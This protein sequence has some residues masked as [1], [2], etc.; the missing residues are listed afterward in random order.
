MDQK[1]SKTKTV[2]FYLISATIGAVFIFSGFVKAI[3]P[4]GTVYKIEDYLVAMHLEALTPLATVGAFALFTFEFSAGVMLLFNRNLKLG[5]W[6]TT[7]FMV[8]MTAMTIWIAAADPVSDCGCFGDAIVLSNK[9]TLIK[10]IIIDL[11]LAVLWFLHG[12]ITPPQSKFT[13]YT[14][15]LAFFLAIIGFGVHAINNLPLIDFRPYKI[16]TNILEA[17]ELP[18]GATP[19]EYETTFIYSKDGIE[20]EFTIQNVPYN[21]STWTFV[22]QHTVLVKKG[23]EPLIHDFVITNLDGEDITDDL[24]YSDRKIY[25]AV[26]YDLGKTK[27][28]NLCNVEKI[29]RK[30]MDEGA[31]FLA[32]TASASQIEEFKQQ[33]GIEYD[34]AVAD[35]IM[36]KTMVRAN[37]GIVVIKDAVIIEKFNPNCHC[38]KF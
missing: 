38:K 4:L 27:K 33:N 10:N 15:N 11:M 29:Y 3:D 21:D 1:Y 9:A 32:L 37:P 22:D 23:D 13:A 2:I 30:A 7:I 26:M 18:E 28:R 20:K 31:D 16:G 8:V 35:P 5:L 17:M 12:I 36:L 34:F 19:D 25:L 24:L 14:I 6:I